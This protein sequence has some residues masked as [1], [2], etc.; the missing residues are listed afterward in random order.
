MHVVIF[1]GSRWPTFAPLSL[2]RPVFCLASGMSTL[3]EK[4]IRY[5]EPTR[6]S[7]W[8][9]PG[10]ATYT[11]NQIVPDLK[12]PTTVNEPLDDEPALLL[13]GPPPPHPPPPPPSPPTT[14]GPPPPPGPS[15]RI[16]RRPCPRAD[17]PPISGT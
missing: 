6:L 13:S 4:Q 5:L 15:S 10:L 3:L 16:P 1:E 9:R 7:L 12:I 17:S 2:S 8:V 11:R 14:S